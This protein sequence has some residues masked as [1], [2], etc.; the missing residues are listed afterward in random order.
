MHP[1]RFRALLASLLLSLIALHPASASK[2]IDM[3]LSLLEP[4]AEDFQK[5][6]D[7]KIFRD[8]DR[9][10]L[11]LLTGHCVVFGTPEEV[12]EVVTDYGNYKHWN[13]NQTRSD[14]LSQ[15]GNVTILKC[16]T[17]IPFPITDRKFTLRMSYGSGFIG[18][19]Q[20]YMSYWSLEPPGEDENLKE[21]FGYWQLQPF[22]ER[23]EFTLVKYVSYSDSGIW[24]PTGFFKSEGKKILKRSMEGLR[25]RHAI[26]FVKEKDPSKVLAAED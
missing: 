18:N 3:S 15:D 20:V 13:G 17:K 10:K 2:E 22:G 26:M 9:G 7:G 23:G 12:F 8:A 11:D 14:I 19:E 4:A 25:D 24:V 6:M 16:R 21:S 1:F 5:L